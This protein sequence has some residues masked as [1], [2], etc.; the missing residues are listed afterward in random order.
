M[1]RVSHPAR[2]FVPTAILASLAL[3]GLAFVAE[4]PTYRYAPLFLI[5]LLWVVF[6]LR[7]RL[8]LHPFHYLLFALGL[9][10]HNLG[11]F[12]L[13][14]RNVL[15]VSFDVYVHFYFGVVGTL[16]VRRA[17]AQSRAG[18]HGAW[19]V[20]ALAV[21]LV[22]GMGAIH[23]LV[24]Y[25]SYLLL[26]EERGMLKPSRGYPLDTQRD[27][28]NNFLGALTALVLV[29]VWVIVRGGGERSSA[30]STGR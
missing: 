13:Y 22:M 4:L 20:A 30:G 12:G 6:V 28:L 21:L 2:R 19:G 27:L 11:A 24:E 7:R 9:V 17:I 1:A 5:P 29:G 8:Y 14:Q 16:I 26:G 15:G 18:P 25:A 3:L 10:L 23:E